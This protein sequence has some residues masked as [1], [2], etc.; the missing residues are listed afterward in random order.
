MK[1]IVAIIWVTGVSA[2][3]GVFFAKETLAIYFADKVL[4][5]NQCEE[6]YNA[7]LIEHQKLIM[8]AERNKMMMDL[9][10]KQ[11]NENN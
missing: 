5:R 1:P 4:N 3:V 2:Y 11:K 6:K 10:N 7:L 8:I 9:Q